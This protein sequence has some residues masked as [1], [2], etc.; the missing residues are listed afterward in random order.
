MAQTIRDRDMYSIKCPIIIYPYNRKCQAG[1]K[2][3]CIAL[4]SWLHLAFSCMPFQTSAMDKL[5]TMTRV[6]FNVIVATPDATHVV[7]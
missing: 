2:V 6:M 5:N 3:N 7:S 4:S 1:V